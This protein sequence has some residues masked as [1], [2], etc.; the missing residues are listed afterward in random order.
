MQHK[1]PKSQRQI[2]KGLKRW[3]NFYWHNSLCLNCK[4]F[5]LTYHSYYT[6]CTYTNNFYLY[7]FIFIFYI[8]KVQLQDLL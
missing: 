7:F 6:F 4:Y 2:K 1:A 8:F 3:M 5:H